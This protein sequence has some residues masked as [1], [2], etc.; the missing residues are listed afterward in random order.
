MRS[1]RLPSQEGQTLVEGRG[2]GDLSEP[3]FASEALFQKFVRR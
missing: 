1:A 2:W 3:S